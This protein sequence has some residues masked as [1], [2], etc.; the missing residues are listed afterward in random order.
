MN[1]KHRK[2]LEA[3]FS[4]PINGNL[5]WRKIEALFLAS[6]AELN[7]RSG[8]R[9]SFALSGEKLRCASSAPWKRGAEVPS[10]R[11]SQFSNE[12][13]Y[14]PMNSMSYNGYTAHIEYDDD[15]GIFVGHLAGIRDIVS[16]HGSTVN[17]LR[18]HFHDAVD[19]Y[20]AVCAERGEQPQKP[21]SG[22]LMLRNL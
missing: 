4:E 6:G 11:C 21:Y 19:H 2:T 20:L 16:F 3:I 9:V 17:E 5:E 14:Y 15:D 12:R 18:V 13:R 8:S 7:E 10:E 1:S 22:N